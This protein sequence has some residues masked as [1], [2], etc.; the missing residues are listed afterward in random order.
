[1][2]HPVFGRVTAMQGLMVGLAGFN[3]GDV[4]CQPPDTELLDEMRRCR[5][6]LRKIT[7]EDLGFDLRR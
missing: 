7:G 5:T 2:S 6:L 4:G 3:S 1:M